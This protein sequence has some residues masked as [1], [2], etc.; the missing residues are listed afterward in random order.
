MKKITGNDLRIVPGKKQLPS[1]CDICYASS[2]LFS[3]EKYLL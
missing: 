1:F 2:A 3:M